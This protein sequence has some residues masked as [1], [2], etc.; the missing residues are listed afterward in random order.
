M[1]G[2]PGHDPGQRTLVTWDRSVTGGTGGGDPA[3]GLRHLWALEDFPCC[4]PLHRLSRDGLR[5][6]L[7]SVPGAPP[8]APSPTRACLR[9]KLLQWRP[10]RRLRCAG[11]RA[12]HVSYSEDSCVLPVLGLWVAGPP[13]CTCSSHALLAPRTWSRLFF[14]LPGSPSMPPCCHLMATHVLEKDVLS[15]KAPELGP[16]GW[17]AETNR[18]VTL[19]GAEGSLG[20]PAV[21]SH[22]SH[23]VCNDKTRLSHPRDL[24]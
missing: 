1:A 17:R 18:G 24:R 4:A 8:V 2:E 13:P 15:E 21:S 11:F 23:Q 9:Q 5:A 19:Q 7:G 20:S 16:H 3:R 10:A 22:P 12:V 6:G 14:H